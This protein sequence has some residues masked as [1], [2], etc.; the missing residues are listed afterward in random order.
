MKTQNKVQLIGYVGKDPVI[1]T[2]SK[3]SK[4]ARISVATDTFF[5]NG[6]GKNVRVTTWHEVVAWEKKAEEVENNFIKGS[7][8]L[9][10]GQIIYKTY[11]DYTG[12]IRY[13]TEIKAQTLM[14]L[15]R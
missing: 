13:T 7:H 1:T 5:K 6:S 12:H 9:V 15:D 14:N 4:L 10:E 11:P 2:T 3:G 8:I